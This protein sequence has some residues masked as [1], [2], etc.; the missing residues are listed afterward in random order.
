MFS[1]HFSVETH[2]IP[3]CRFVYH[4]YDS[5]TD[6]RSIQKGG[7]RI[8]V[9]RRGGKGSGLAYLLLFLGRED[10]NSNAVLAFIDVPNM[11]KSASLVINPA[12][13]RSI[14]LGA[15]TVFR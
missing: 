13:N 10:K 7:K 2:S 3:F 9:G 1:V 11:W 15:I 8:P 4:R 12:S 5:D 6:D 14:I